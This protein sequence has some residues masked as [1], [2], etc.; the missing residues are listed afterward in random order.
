MQPATV[1]LLANRAGD[2]IDF[3]QIWA[4][5]DVPAEWKEQ[6]LRIWS[7]E[8]NAV[9]QQSAS[10]RMISEWAKRPECWEAVR[11]ASY[12]ALLGGHS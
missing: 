10:G 12:S 9:L 8:V 2:R 3:D 6:L 11:N 7:V 4:Q 1:A 5:Q